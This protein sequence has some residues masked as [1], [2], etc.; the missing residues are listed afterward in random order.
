MPKSAL[1]GPAIA[2]NATFYP[3]VT[4]ER[5]ELPRITPV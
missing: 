4:I 3:V 5:L 1:Y 2:G